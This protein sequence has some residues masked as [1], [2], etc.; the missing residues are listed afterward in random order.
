MKNSHQIVPASICLAWAMVLA[1]CGD[2]GQGTQANVKTASQD[3]PAEAAKAAPAGDAPS[4]GDA[5]AAMIA[6]TGPSEV[7][8]ALTDV[9]PTHPHDFS[10]LPKPP[11][12]DPA[13]YVVKA[14]PTVLDFGDVPTNDSKE[15]KLRLVNTGDTP[16]TIL[17]ANASCGCTALRVTPNT[18]IE[19]GEALDIDV[20]LSG[21][22]TPG[23]LQGKKVTFVIQ[24]HPDLIVDVH[25]NAKS[26]VVMEPLQLDPD[27]VPDGKFKL[28]S[29]DGTAFT[30]RSMLPS[31][32]TE[33]GTEPKIEHELALPWDRFREIGGNR[34]LVFYL[35]HPKCGQVQGTVLMKP[36][37][38]T[39]LQ[40]RA[41]TPPPVLDEVTLLT[42]WIKEGRT[43]EIQ[44]KLDGG[45]DVN[46]RAQDGRTLLSLAAH[47][48]QTAI[49][50]MLIDKGADIEAVDRNGRTPM[51]WAAQSKKVEAVQFLLDAG[52][53]GHARDNLNLTPL[54]WAAWTGDAASVRELLDVGSDVNI[55][56][57]FTGWTPL[58][59]AAAFGDPNAVEPLI[60]AGSD[61]EVADMLQGATALHNAVRTGKIESVQALLKHGAN[62]EA[63]DRNG[64]TALLTAASAAGA[65]AAKV[66]L[67]IDAG[68]DLSAVDNRKLNALELARK[69][70]DPRAAEVVALLEKL[71]G[72]A[73]PAEPAPAE[74]AGGQ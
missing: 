58:I 57:S 27:T 60:K 67:L 36:A 30:V 64:N 5:A 21:G 62:L 18:V 20:R 17:R 54:A 37:V 65:D 53:D 34:K 73:Q 12:A 50:K 38:N 9:A 52:A 68:A 1:G 24:D 40:Q 31:V 2:S 3:T 16:R 51:M 43:A 45:T 42:N 55:V 47:E 74:P 39:P 11:V 23:P 71:I 35:D 10:H 6:P 14:E 25:A 4:A 44:A 63:V 46:L 7:H 70:T 28:R 8:P 61:L 48:G 13:A 33:F 72:A 69:R 26:Y 29:I 22:A 59:L 41:A 66:K 49:M 56:G 15:I 19:P 32:I